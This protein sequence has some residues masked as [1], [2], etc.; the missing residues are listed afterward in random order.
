MS[1]PNSAVHATAIASNIEEQETGQ[2]EVAADVL[3]VRTLFVNFFVYG[4]PGAQSGRW[5]LIDT[6]LGMSFNHIL[7]VA[8]QRF[9]A[10][11]KPHAI[12]LTHG[13]FDH[14]GACAGL[15][16]KWDVPVYAHEL[17]LPFLTG[18]QH[19]PEPD[20]TVDNGLIARMSV[21]FP[22][23]AVDLGDRIQVL[24]DDGSVPGM[25]GWRWIHVPGHAP[26]QVAL[27]REDDRILLAADAFVT[28]QQESVAAVLSQRPG[29][30]GPPKY[31]TTDWLAAKDSVRRLTALRPRVAAT[32]HGV[33]LAGDALTAGLDTLVQQFERLAVPPQG[34]YVP[35]GRTL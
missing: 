32:G 34:K 2:F 35:A 15:A 3:C 11:S 14:V 22:H 10:N 16:E 4:E 20:P 9:G 28:V 5:V 18:E 13:H 21:F 27:F 26:G 23:N 17:E 1:D 12:I 30:F 24:P 7:E 31:F 6:G 29:V 25:P 8:E 33:P 19:Y